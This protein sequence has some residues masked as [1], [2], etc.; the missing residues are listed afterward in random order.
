MNLSLGKKVTITES[1]YFQLKADFYNVL[2][3]KNFTISNANVF[4]T[5]GVTAATSNPGY[6]NIL[7]PSFLNPKIF[8]GGN[9]QISLTARFV[10]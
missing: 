3:H 7:D 2:N 8:S 10:F 5:A 1:A 9:R 4:S 6:V